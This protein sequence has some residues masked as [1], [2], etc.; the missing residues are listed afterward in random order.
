MKPSFLFGSLHVL[1]LLAQVL[2]S[3]AAV[4]LLCLLL[5]SFLI[6]PYYKK[7]HAESKGNKEILVL[8]MAAFVFF[9]LTVCTLL[10]IIYSSKKS[11]PVF[12]VQWFSAF[13]HTCIILSHVKKQFVLI[14]LLLTNTAGDRVFGCFHGA[15]LFPGWSFAVHAGSHG[16]SGGHGMHRADQRFPRHHLLRLY[17]SDPIWQFIIML[18]V[19]T[20]RLYW[21]CVFVWR[22]RSPRVPDVCAVWTH[23]SA[24]ADPHPCHYEGTALFSVLLFHFFSLPPLLTLLLIFSQFMMA[25][26]VLSAIL[27]PGSRYIRWVVSAG[28]AQ[29]SEFSFVLSSRA[30]RAGIISREVSEEL[31][32]D[33]YSTLQT[34]LSVP[35]YFYIQYWNLFCLF[36]FITT[37]FKFAALC[38]A[39][40]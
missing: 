34:N 14:F 18:H 22:C 2:V 26:L 19:C 38:D 23:H 7:L 29:V 4:L 40:F 15:G 27:P 10:L 13:L 28:L 12:F 17:W 31:M 37:D 35:V 30:R 20:A 32:F 33:S 1:Y 24:G 25:V 11:Y 8:G 36:A 16:Y 5:K 9:M 3:L 39:F 6:G 21:S